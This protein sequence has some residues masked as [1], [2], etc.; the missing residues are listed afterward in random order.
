MQTK[1]FIVFVC[2]K[3]HLGYFSTAGGRIRSATLLHPIR[4]SR[5][6]ASELYFR[7]SICVPETIDAQGL[8]SSSRYTCCQICVSRSFKTKKKP[9]TYPR[10]CPKVIQHLCKRRPTVMQQSS[11]SYAKVVHMLCKSRSKV[12]Q[13]SS[14]SYAKVIKQLCESHQTLMQTSC[15]C[16]HCC[17]CSVC[18]NRCMANN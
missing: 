7:S 4:V 2:W 13:K 11:N 12:M 18:V 16:M 6:E 5:G 9:K 15:L 1:M 10:R 14:K 8:I 3:I 17:S